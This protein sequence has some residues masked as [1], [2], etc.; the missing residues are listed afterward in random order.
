MRATVIDATEKG[1]ALSLHRGLLSIWRRTEFL[2]LT[3]VSLY[4]GS[5]WLISRVYNHPEAFRGLLYVPVSGLAFFVVLA[6]YLIART[7][8]IM[9]WLHPYY[10]IRTL[11]NDFSQT[12]LNPQRLLSALPFVFT[13]F[14]FFGAFSS[15]KSMIPIIN[16]YSWDLTFANLDKL[17]HGGVHPWQLLQS[18]LGYPRVTTAL[19]FFYNLWFFLL[20]FIFFWQALTFHL[21]RLR[22][23]FLLTF[24]LSWIVI[25]HIFATFFSSAGPCYYG[26]VIG[27]EQENPYAELMNY[28]QQANEVSPVWVV[29]TQALLWQTYEEH[30]LMPGSGISAMPSMHVAMAALFTFLAVQLGRPYNFLFTAYLIVIVFGSV[31]LAWHY[32]VDAYVAILLTYGIWRFSG[33]VVRNLE[34]E[35]NSAHAG[36]AA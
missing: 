14:V 6:A 16:P 20:I 24:F 19:N 28:L 12:F 5:A 34:T 21:P 11:R 29:K 27:R 22:L 2:I 3:I 32:A 25:G 35:K 1:Q 23:Q 26:A 17:F 31:H 10:L 30:N 13:F 18:L 15:M 33:L 4:V 36:E 7:L 8:W 9:I